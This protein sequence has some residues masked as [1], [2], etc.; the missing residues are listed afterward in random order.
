MNK[1]DRKQASRLI[2]LCSVIYCIS[3][4]TRINFKAVMPGIMSDTGYAKSQL[5]LAM[6]GLFVAYG[7]GQLVSGYFGDR[8]QPRHLIAGGLIATAAMNLLIPFC[9]NHIW[10]S[11]VWTVNGLAQAFMWPPLVKL[12][13]DQMNMEDYTRGTV[14]V[15][16]GA[17]IGTILVYLGTAALVAWVTWESVFFG[18]ALI[19]VVGLIA[20]WFLCPTIDLKGQERVRNGGSA[21]RS[22]RPMIL[23]VCLL[24]AI[25]MMGILRDGVDTFM[26]IYI[27]EQ[28][29]LG[30]AISI[31]TGVAMPVFALVCQQIAGLLFNKVFNDAFRSAVIIFF[32]GV[33]AAL[34][35][36]FVNQVNGN[37]ILSVF[38]LALLTGCMHGVNMNLICILPPILAGNGKVSAVSGLL[39]SFTYVGSAISMYVI[40]LIAENASWSVTILMWIGFALVG[41]TLNLLCL[42]IWKRHQA[43][44]RV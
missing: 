12:M 19:A 37:V 27:E 10:M 4:I 16:W 40:P 30:D 43:K 2:L 38:L 24:G 25:V 32:V 22:K 5:S 18:A 42:P 31:L 14:R 36:Y 15:N 11:V 28:Y 39:N 1:L 6:A 35:L 21:T 3:Y 20:W 33:L 26:P 9:T 7:A 13:A 41:T 34:A 8:V 23:M 44:Q 29:H 17:S